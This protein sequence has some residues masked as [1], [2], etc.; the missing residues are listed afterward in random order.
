MGSA[1]ASL[2]AAFVVPFNCI[3]YLIFV[4]LINNRITVLK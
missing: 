2:S 1:G 3:S 4:A